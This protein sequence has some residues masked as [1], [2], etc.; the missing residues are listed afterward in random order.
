MPSQNEVLL[1]ANLQVG[2]FSAVLLH[3]AFEPQTFKWQEEVG[4]KDKQPKAPRRA[5]Q[6]KAASAAKEEQVQ[7]PASPEFFDRVL[8]FYAVQFYA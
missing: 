5:Q 7:A 1:V 2:V 4:M 6:R 8:Q 3:Q